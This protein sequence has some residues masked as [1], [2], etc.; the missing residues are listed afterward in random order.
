MDLIRWITEDQAAKLVERSPRTLRLWRQR[1]E[2]CAF[3]Q[4]GIAGLVLYD[5]TTLRACAATQ[6]MRLQQGRPPAN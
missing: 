4:A 3:K 1:G 2:V 5:E 6:V